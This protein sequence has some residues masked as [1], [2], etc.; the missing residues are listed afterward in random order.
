MMDEAHFTAP[1]IQKLA[2][3]INCFAA[4]GSEMLAHK[5]GAY[6]RAYSNLENI[7]RDDKE[8]LERIHTLALKNKAVSALRLSEDLKQLTPNAGHIMGLVN[9]CL[10]AAVFLSH[11]ISSSE[12]ALAFQATNEQPATQRLH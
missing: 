8:L 12:K 2:A 3:L 9:Q 1:E 4:I 5:G 11:C 10:M 6:A 7:V